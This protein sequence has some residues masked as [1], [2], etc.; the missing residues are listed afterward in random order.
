M[1]PSI[2]FLIKIENPQ[3]KHKKKINFMRETKIKPVWAQ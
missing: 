3:K 1:K 2:F